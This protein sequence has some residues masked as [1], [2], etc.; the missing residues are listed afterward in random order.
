MQRLQNNWKELI[1]R[2]YWRKWKE[3]AVA[4]PRAIILVVWFSLRHQNPIPPKA[5]A[6]VN[7]ILPRAAPQS[8]QEKKANP[9]RF[10]AKNLHNLVAPKMCDEE[11]AVRRLSFRTLWALRLLRPSQVRNILERLMPPG[12]SVCQTVVLRVLFW[13][14]A[15]MRRPL[16]G[17]VLANGTRSFRVS[18]GGYGTYYWFSNAMINALVT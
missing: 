17:S 16:L 8:C 10:R 15:S 7:A 1:I 18:V 9:A 13:W 4:K 14:M 12:G 6:A 11:R 5:N 3:R 2:S